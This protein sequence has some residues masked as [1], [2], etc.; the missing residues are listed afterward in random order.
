[1]S[2][3]QENS[4]NLSYDIQGTLVDASKDNVYD[5]NEIHQT[6]KT[7]GPEPSTGTKIIVE[8]E[9]IVKK[10]NTD[11]EDL[12]TRDTKKHSEDPQNVTSPQE[13]PTQKQ[14]FKNTPNSGSQ[15]DPKI[16]D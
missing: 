13:P 2:N 6:T 11:F 9:T 14:T 7:V 3:N 8:S 12:D 5:V 4:E 16:V 1:M 15:E 10:D